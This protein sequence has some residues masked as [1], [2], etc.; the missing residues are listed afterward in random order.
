MARFHQAPGKKRNT[1]NGN[2]SFMSDAGSAGAGRLTEFTIKSPGRD[3]LIWD[4]TDPANPV[5]IQYSRTG[6]NINSGLSTTP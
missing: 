5:N 1:Y 6:E 2:I 4:I 3:P